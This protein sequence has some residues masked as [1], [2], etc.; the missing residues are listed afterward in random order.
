MRGRPR[1]A[2]GCSLG[3]FASCHFGSPYR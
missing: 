2:R 1:R 3:W